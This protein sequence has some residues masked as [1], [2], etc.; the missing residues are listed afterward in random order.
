[1]SNIWEYIAYAE[2]YIGVIG[3]FGGF[4][5]AFY[6]LRAVKP[7]ICIAGFLTSTI[8]ALLIFYAVYANSAED[9]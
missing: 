3:I 4:M 5:L 8:L 1:M 6:G 2:P 7:S 9:L